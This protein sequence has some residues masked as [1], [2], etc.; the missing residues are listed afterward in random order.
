MKLHAIAAAAVSIFFGVGTALAY[1]PVDRS[2]RGTLDPEQLERLEID[3]VQSG[4]LA[5]GP[6]TATV[7]RTAR[8]AQR[9]TSAGPA[10]YP[11]VHHTR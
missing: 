4:W 8:P 9:G 7:R 2:L 11:T 5:G 6:S 3:H 1:H 10:P